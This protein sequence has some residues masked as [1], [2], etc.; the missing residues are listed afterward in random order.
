MI[1]FLFLYNLF[2]YFTFLRCVL[3]ENASAVLSRSGDGAYTAVF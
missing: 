1:T 3:A 2:G